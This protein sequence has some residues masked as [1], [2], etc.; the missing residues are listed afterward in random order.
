MTAHQAFKENDIVE[1]DF[2]LIDS[3]PFH[4]KIEWIRYNKFLGIILVD[5]SRIDNNKTE[6]CEIQFIKRIVES[7]CLTGTNGNCR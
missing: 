4:A 7:N 2:N 6:S 1:I 5:V 3:K